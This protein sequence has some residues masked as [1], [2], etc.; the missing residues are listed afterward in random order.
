MKG[1]GRGSR[2]RRR[3]DRHDR[4]G[5]AVHR[6]RRVVVAAQLHARAATPGAMMVPMEALAA[7]ARALR[8][9]GRATGRGVILMRVATWSAV[10]AAA[11]GAAAAGLT[12]ND[13]AIQLVDGVVAKRGGGSHHGGGNVAL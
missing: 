7:G 4:L 5:C 11:A 1:A 12:S 3:C 6:R 13:V 8:R 2:C 9:A 10:A